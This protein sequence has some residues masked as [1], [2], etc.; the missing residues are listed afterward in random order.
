MIVYT[1]ARVLS[2]IP[3]DQKLA[4]IQV[5]LQLSGSAKIARIAFSLYDEAGDRI[6][7]NLKGMPN[8]K[9]SPQDCSAIATSKSGL[10]GDTLDQALSRA[11][12]STIEAC[13][14]ISGGTIA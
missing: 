14:G 6:T 4:S 7:P 2:F 10:A 5:D 13:L 9:I 8:S 1:P 11:A 12:L 3:S